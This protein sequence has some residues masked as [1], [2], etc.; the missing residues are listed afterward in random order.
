MRIWKQTLDI[1]DIQ[2]IEVPNGAKMLDA[3]M[4]NGT[5]A[6]WFLCD[7]KNTKVTRNI[8]IYGTGEPLPYES[9]E[10]IGTF[11]RVKD[12]L[13]FHVFEMV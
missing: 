9:G 5:L 7:E 8:A 3:Q 1:K 2:T 4:Q 12:S 11:R 13:V 6:L 10:Y